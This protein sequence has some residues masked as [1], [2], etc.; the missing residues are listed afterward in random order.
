[1]SDK[2][3][4]TSKEAIKKYGSAVDVIKEHKKDNAYL[5]VTAMDILYVEAIVELEEKIDEMKR[6]INRI[7]EE[8]KYIPR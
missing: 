3:N 5:G 1:M 2:W 8:L 4:I 7:N 6:E